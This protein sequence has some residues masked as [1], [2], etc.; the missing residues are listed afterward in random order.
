MHAGGTAGLRVKAISR[1]HGSGLGA[2]NGQC[3]LL[4]DW[5]PCHACVSVW[6]V[7][8]D[9]TCLTWVGSCVGCKEAEQKAPFKGSETLP[10]G[11]SGPKR[12]PHS[13]QYEH[14]SAAAKLGRA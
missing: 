2:R 3:E 14:W 12:V 13:H 1:I 7:T 10:A 4:T 9:Q 8:G 6:S 5:S 11:D